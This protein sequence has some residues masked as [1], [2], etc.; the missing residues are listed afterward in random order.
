MN[1]FF[2]ITRNTPYLGDRVDLDI[3]IDRNKANI[4]DDHTLNAAM[5]FKWPHGNFVVHPHPTHV[6]LYG[7]WLTTWTPTNATCPEENAIFI[8]DDIVAS[9]VYY[10]WLKSL[11]TAYANRTDISGFSLQRQWIFAGKNAMRFISVPEERPAFLYRIHGTWGFSPN[12][13][14]WVKFLAWY[15]QIKNNKYFHP[16]IPEATVLT[17][18]YKYHQRQKKEE[19]VWSQWLMYYSF[20]NDLYCVYPN[21]KNSDLVVN[22]MLKGLHMSE[23]EVRHVSLVRLMQ[24][25]PNRLYDADP[26]KIHYDGTVIP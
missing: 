20:I 18:G 4:L 25:L 21:Y 19:N 1:T 16:Y 6:G 10:Q 15:N 17:G 2:V 12:R 24:H 14:N 9:K 23:S 11:H 26:V 13:R 8:E 22:K 5:T 7:Q 3:Y